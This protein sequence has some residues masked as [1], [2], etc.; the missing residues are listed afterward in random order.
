M[1]DAFGFISG[2][3]QNVRRIRPVARRQKLILCRAAA[4]KVSGILLP[5]AHSSRLGATRNYR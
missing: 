1:V 4:G 2:I 3:E 5:D